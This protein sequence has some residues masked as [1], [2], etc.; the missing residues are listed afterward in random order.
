VSPGQFMTRRFSVPLVSLAVLALLAA[1]CGGG[2]KKASSTTPTTT[3]K[4]C[5]AKLTGSA[6]ATV[7]NT[8]ITRAQFD[9][10]VQQAK[11]NYKLQKRNF[12]AVGSP[13]Y[14]T[15]SGQIMAFLVQRSEF[16]QKAAEMGVKV[17]DKQVANRLTQIKKQYFAGSEARYQAQLK[18]Q[19]LTDA[20]VRNDIHAQLIS[21]GLYSKVT[22]SITVS[23]KSVSDYYN[24]HLSDQYTQPART[25]P[26]SR[27]VR[28]ILVKTKAQADQLYKQLKAGAD[29]AALAKKYTLDTSS[30]ATG[31][32]LTISKGQT[33]PQFDKTA[34]ALKTNQISQPVHTRFGW[35]I[36]QA[37]SDVTPAKKVP[38]KVTPLSQV[39]SAIKAQLLSQKKSQAMQAW[40]TKTKAEFA[41]A[42]HYAAGFTP[43]STT[44]T[45]TTPAQTT[46]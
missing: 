29:F 10:V 46:G 36:I 1:G 14:R 43:P 34:F 38:K 4:N 26:A 7:C 30:K 3:P 41:P 31:G 18:Q 25:D 6:V 44:A 17:T 42:I 35:H 16:A 5:T 15:L 27:K 37:L 22:S 23:D 28:H 32:A 24:Q 39:K 9:D 33:V 20:E 13:D 11:R 21:D 12:P 8:T 2:G 40:I 19:G 45:T